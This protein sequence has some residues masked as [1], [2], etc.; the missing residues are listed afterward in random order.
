MTLTN[1]APPV[2]CSISQ[3][4]NLL[5]FEPLG[6]WPKQLPAIAINEWVIAGFTQEMVLNHQLLEKDW[7]QFPG[8]FRSLHQDL[9]FLEIVRLWDKSRN[10]EWFPISAV[11]EAYHIRINEQFEQM[12]NICLQLPRNFQ[13][14]CAQKKLG[15][16]DFLPLLATQNLNLKSVFKKI[17]DLK[18]SKADGVQALEL[19]TDLLLLGHSF[20]EL[21][22]EASTNTELS[23]PTTETWLQ[24]LKNLRFPMTKNKD[25]NAESNLMKLPWPGASQVKWTRQG[26]KAGIEVK[27]FVSQPEDLNRYARSFDKIQS[28]MESTQEDPWKLQ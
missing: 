20:E 17:L 13:D 22:L 2:L 4:K 7:H 11:A 24:H 10:S 28:M 1:S 25:L 15:L 23:I 18:L 8:I 27:L 21:E 9:S 19:C 12:A 5:N 26:D 16:G 3:C 6:Y 14:W